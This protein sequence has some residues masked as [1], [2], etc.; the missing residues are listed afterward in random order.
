MAQRSSPIDFSADRPIQS[1]DAD[2]L[3][4]RGFAEHIAAAVRGWAGHDSLVLALYGQWGSGKSSL[5]YMVVE[6]LRSDKA[7]SPYI[8]EFSPWQWAGQEQLAQA[9]FREIGKQ[10]GRK[11]G[12]KQAKASADRWLKYGAL[13][14]LG[15]EVFSGTRRLALVALG[16]IVSLSF[17]GA[18]FEITAVRIAL[19]VIAFLSCIGFALLVTSQRFAKGV[20]TYFSTV[21]EAEEKSLDEVK[22]ELSGY[23]RALNR[24]VLVV[25][26]DVDRLTGPET[27]LL[28]QLIKA[29]A[30]FP[31]MVYL[32]LFQ[33]ETV[34]NALTRELST[35]GSEYLKK[36]VQVGFDVPRIQRSRLEV[37]LTSKLN[38]LLQ[39]E[40]V[41][42]LWEKE[43]W[44]DIFIPGLR[45]YFETLRDVYR[46]ISVLSLQVAVF[47]RGG[48][49]EVN[50]IDLVSLEVL[51]VFEPE[52]YNSLHASKDALTRVDDFGSSRSRAE[53]TEKNEIQSI[54]Q[55][56]S[57]AHRER[58]KEILTQ[59]F[60]PV[61]WVFSNVRLTSDHSDSWYRAHRA[62]HPG[63]FDKY[64]Y[65]TI[66]EG[67]LSHE[68][69]ERIVA[70]AGDRQAFA[71]E[72]RA[73]GKRNLLGVAID[74]LE[75]YKET[76]SLDHA[77]SFLT[78]MFDTGDELPAGQVGLT[79]IPPDLHAA[80]IVYWYLKREPEI[81]KRQGILIRCIEQTTGLYL[82][83]FV[84][85][86]EG[87]K[88][89][90]GR[91]R[92]ERLADDPGLKHLQDLCVSKIRQAATDGTL[93]GNPRLGQLLGFWLAWSTG[94]EARNWVATLIESHYGL[95]SF[96]VASLRETRTYGVARYSARSSWCVD[97]EGIEKLVAPE[98]IER[99]LAGVKTEELE[100]K[101]SQAVEAFRKAMKRKR[102]GKPPMSILDADA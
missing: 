90:E 13:L 42:S 91:E 63:V 92:R 32:V 56:A 30:D 79:E 94:D 22:Y 50:P 62:C 35:D 101:P 39:S 80:R 33:R 61:S 9:F 8:V 74:R 48:A 81:S 71:S 47:S 11:E 1:R 24:P 23:L 76:I 7:K 72:L 78:A 75:A 38:A 40:P 14:G 54:L 93:S 98:L 77:I 95:L 84:V 34:E 6:S 18:F 68:E 44:P 65:L 16:I 52:V 64:F 28:F 2:L 58:V 53:T 49:F 5:K 70:L 102:E 45:P 27:R 20:A 46:F 36:I 85:A 51:R 66:P 60:P 21:A 82:P 97:L 83:C 37:I 100:A 69:V 41:K 87:D 3:D 15:P 31:N 99:K 17:A 59:V 19:G 89:K 67:E 57:E 73:T 96:L 29:N 10:L 86:L 26:D 88:L 4:R 25:I 55:R 12:T 43:R